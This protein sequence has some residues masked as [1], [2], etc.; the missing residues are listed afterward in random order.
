M[1]YVSITYATKYRLRFAPHYEFTT[2]GICVNRKSGKQIKKVYNNRCIGYT[3]N[4]RFY[5]LKI[6]RS[7]LEKIPNKIEFLPF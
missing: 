1:N 6:L 2:S 4:G 7:E 5:S 3:I